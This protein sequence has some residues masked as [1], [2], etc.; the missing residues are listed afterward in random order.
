[1]SKKLDKRLK[2]KKLVEADAQGN[3]V[4]RGK[5]TG[6]GSDGTNLP[7]GCDPNTTT[8]YWHVFDT[9]TMLGVCGPCALVTYRC[10]T[11]IHNL[12]AE[13]LLDVMRPKKQIAVVRGL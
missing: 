11:M 8:H 6:C 2:P 5:C 9:R 4:P 10:I 1:M 12:M 7:V 13:P 3:E